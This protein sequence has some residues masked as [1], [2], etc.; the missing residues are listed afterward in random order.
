[1]KYV[2][3]DTYLLYLP[4]SDVHN[5]AMTEAGERRQATGVGIQHEWSKLARTNT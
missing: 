3:F 4:L 5:G 1:M 2:K